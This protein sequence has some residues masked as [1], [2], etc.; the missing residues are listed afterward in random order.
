[1][2]RNW[3]QMHL[4]RSLDVA[5]KVICEDPEFL[6]YLKKVIREDIR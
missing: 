6:E 5:D 1:M 3:D 2:W 4:N